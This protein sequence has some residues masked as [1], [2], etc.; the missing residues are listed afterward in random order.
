MTAQ[1]DSEAL[2]RLVREIL[3]EA[4]PAR[5]RSTAK[6]P[7]RRPAPR[8]ANTQREESVAIGSDAE[9][10]AF[11]DRLLRLFENPAGREALRSGRHVFRL[12][13]AAKGGRSG[14][15]GRIQS[16]EGGTGHL[17]K[18]VLSEAKLISLAKTGKRITL[19]KSVTVTP[20]AKDKARQLGVKLERE[21]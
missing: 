9:L 18:G 5:V 17:D 16:A 3:R 7:A 6:T 13:Q 2:R 12:A 11:V 8:A 20:L 21:S 4:I 1:L 10:Q 15:N 14:G 19:G